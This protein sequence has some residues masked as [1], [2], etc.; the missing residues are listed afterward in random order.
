MTAAFSQPLSGQWVYDSVLAVSPW[1]G[2]AGQ[3]DRF[4]CGRPVGSINRVLG[5]MV[6]K[7]AHVGQ[8]MPRLPETDSAGTRGS[9]NEN[10]TLTGWQLH[11]LT[12]HRVRCLLCPVEN[13]QRAG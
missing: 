11:V 7:H 13:P 1:A 3:A 2:T 4:E 10:E 9:G 12:Q 6:A 8:I 5:I